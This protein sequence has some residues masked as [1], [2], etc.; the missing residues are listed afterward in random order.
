[1]KLTEKLLTKAYKLKVL[2][3]KL[4]E[5][6]LQRQIYFLT[7]MESLEMIFSQY[8]E[9]FEVLPYYP[10]IGGEDIKDYLKKE[11]RNILHSNIDVYSR[12]LISEFPVDGVKFIS[13][14]QSHFANMTFYD[15]S[16]YDSLFHKVTHKLGGSAMNYINIF[17]N[18]LA[19]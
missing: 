5:D 7:F 3:F 9:I 15:K 1:M 16:K 12:R 11:I 17:Q 13:K 14:I 6:P 19:L 10:I 8:K 2:K 4:D 18:T